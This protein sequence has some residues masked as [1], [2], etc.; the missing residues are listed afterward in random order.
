MTNAA[1][2]RFASMVI[3]ARFL[4]LFTDGQFLEAR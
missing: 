4:A 3:V 2:N 1:F